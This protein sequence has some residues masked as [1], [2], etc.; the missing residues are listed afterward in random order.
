MKNDKTNK[1]KWNR[2]KKAAQ[3]GAMYTQCDMNGG[4]LLRCAIFTFTLSCDN[5]IRTL[6]D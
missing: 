4:I 5:C 2:R 3:C 6:M 1:Y